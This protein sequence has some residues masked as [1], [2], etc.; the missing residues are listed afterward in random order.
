MKLTKSELQ[1]IIKE[2]I[3]ALQEGSFDAVRDFLDAR[4]RGSPEEMV[5]IVQKNERYMRNFIKELA[6]YLDRGD[7][8]I[9][10]ERGHK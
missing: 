1:K 2:E 4:D 5:R 3:E 8:I 9:A 7:E 6:F 10:H